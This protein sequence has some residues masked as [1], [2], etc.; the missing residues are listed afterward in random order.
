MKNISNYS[1]AAILF[2]LSYLA[3]GCSNQEQSDL[4]RL[5]LKGDVSTLE[6]ATQTSIP[7]SEWLYTDISIPDLQRKIRNDAVYSFCG[8]GKFL[9]NNSGNLAKLIVYDNLGNQIFEDPE[10][11]RP[12]TLYN[13]ININVND[14]PKDGHLRLI[15]L[16]V[17]KSKIFRTMV[18]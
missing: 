18:N 15:V 17:L 11:T 10:L 13:P 16:D 1:I 12:L 9:F 5:N 2:C 4:S 6:I 8:Q 7:I 14:C 3:L